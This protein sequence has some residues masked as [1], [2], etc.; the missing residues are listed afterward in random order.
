[1]RPDGVEIDVPRY[2]QPDDL[3]CGPTCLLQ[4]LHS[5][6]IETTYEEVYARNPKNPDGGTL[7]VFLGLTA[8]RFGCGA[9]IYPYDFRTFDPTWSGL[10]RDELRDRLGRRA[11]SVRNRKV[12]TAAKAYMEFLSEGG[13]VLFEELSSTLIRRVL[14]RN[15]PVLCG[16]SATYLYR[17]PRERP[18][19]GEYDDIRGVP[20]G[21]FV[22]VCGYEE[23]GRVFLVCDPSPHAPFGEG[24]RYSVGSR[25][26]LN[27]ILLG[28]LTYDAV[29]LEISPPGTG[30]P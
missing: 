27:S 1:M 16:L 26:L 22:V 13:H 12:K 25:R 6:R 2:Q 28:D 15:R 17:T 21:H 23:G 7:A 24:G 11:A 14:D 3:S 19:D 18:K 8:L 9:T 4:V 20:V 29:L 5:F 30:K 10:G